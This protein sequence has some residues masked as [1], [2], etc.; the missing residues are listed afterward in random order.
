[1]VRAVVVENLVKDYGRFRALHGISF[2]VEE[3]EVFG[4]V[5]P[6]GAGKTTTLRILATLLV[7]T[8]G[9]VTI[10]GLDVV[11]D[12]AKVRKLISYL[13]E[14]AGTY[15]NITGYE[16]LK[17]VA[18]LYFGKGRDAEEAL[19]LG[20]RIAGIG[21]RIHDKMK[22][23]SKGMQRRVQLARAL[24]VRPRLAILDEPTSGLDVAQAIEIRETIKRF[25]KELGITVVMSS[26]NM[27][28]V[29]EVCSRVAIIDRG[30]ILEQGYVDELLRRYGVDNLEKVFLTVVRGGEVEGSTTATG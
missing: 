10:F 7:P 9:R 24:M 22:T 1:M 5:G 19:E 30:R 28:E 11:R 13:P 15:K 26:H 25:S 3:G 18:E 21:D 27:L 4:L 20:I 29:Q 2:T 12:A 6:N 14:E 16:Y 23:Y 17:M 8:S